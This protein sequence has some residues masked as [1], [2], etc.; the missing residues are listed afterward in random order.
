MK[1][2]NKYSIV[3][4][5]SEFLNMD[6]ADPKIIVSCELKKEIINSAFGCLEQHVFGS[7]RSEPE[8]I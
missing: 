8:K 3:T 7:V 2:A 6:W 5:F 4:C 1:H